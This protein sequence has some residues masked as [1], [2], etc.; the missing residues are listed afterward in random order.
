MVELNEK[1]V[2]TIVHLVV[3]AF[4]R[5]NGLFAS[6]V[7]LRVVTTGQVWSCQGSNAAPHPLM[8]GTKI[9]LKKHLKFG[10]RTVG[11]YFMCTVLESKDQGA[12]APSPR[13]GYNCVDYG[14]GGWFPSRRGGDQ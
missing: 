5:C 1:L 14:S 4:K 2:L 8:I 11:M 10:Q 12:E 3:N 9:H 6:S 7:R 13:A